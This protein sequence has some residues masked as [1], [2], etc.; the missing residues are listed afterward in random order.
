M[1]RKQVEIKAG[2]R[3]RVKRDDDHGIMFGAVCSV[4]GTN[5]AG[6]W[7]VSGPAIREGWGWASKRGDTITQS[8]SADLLIPVKA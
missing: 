1:K 5:W 8:V 4:H 2:M 3:V 7:Q 6:E